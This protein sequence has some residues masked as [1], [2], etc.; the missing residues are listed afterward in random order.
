[1]SKRPWLRGGVKGVLVW[2]V[3]S[4]IT[5]II[6][7]LPIWGNAPIDF[8]IQGPV[9]FPGGLIFGI[10]GLYGLGLFFHPSTIST[11]I[12]YFLIGSLIGWFYDK[13]IKKKV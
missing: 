5:L 12:I 9:Y 7:R 4:I 11:I 6:S 2:V 8:I 3:I 10:D 13:K 1:M